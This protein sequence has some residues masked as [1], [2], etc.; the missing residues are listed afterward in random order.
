[1]ADHARPMP[2][3]RLTRSRRDRMCAGVCGGIAEYLG[4]DALVVRLAFVVLAITTGFAVIVYLVAWWLLPTADAGGVRVTGRPPGWLGHLRRDDTRTMIGFGF[5]ACGGLLLLDEL[6]FLFNNAVAFPVTLVAAGLGVAWAKTSQGDRG[7]FL[8][9]ALHGGRGP[10]SVARL[11]GGIVL[12][13]AGGIALLAAG[14]AL[15]DAGSVFL[16]VVVTLGGLA[17]MLGPW[18]YRLVRTLREERRE[19]IRSEERAEVAAHLHDSVLQTLAL[20]QRSAPTR[21]NEVVSLAR[22][23]ERELR[24]W[25][26]GDLDRRRAGTLAVAIE[27]VAAGVEADHGVEVEAVTVGDCP[28]D[29]DV[30]ALVAAVREAAVNAAKHAGVGLVDIY[31]EVES[32]RVTAFVRD[33]GKGFDPDT[34]ADDRRGIADSIRQRMARHGGRVTVNSAPG[35]GTEVGIEVRLNGAGRRP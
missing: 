20:I 30:A 25:L 22:R 27:A 19:R 14:G 31:V 2:A 3:R 32:D 4:I 34:V 6:G 29:P 11:V 35:E 24:S 23:Q 17:L 26:Y 10:A 33:R 15:K 28:V 13:T 18:A 12:V 7:R 21:P 1:M 16:A 8:G 9:A 5:L